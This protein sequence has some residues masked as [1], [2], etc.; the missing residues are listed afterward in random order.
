MLGS[1][2]VAAPRAEAAVDV[3]AP[4]F[5]PHVDYPTGVARRSSALGDLN[6]DSHLDV[7]TG[8]ITVSK[9]SVL[10][11]NGAGGFGAHVDYSVP[12]DPA[13]LAVADVTGDG[14][15]DVVVAQLSGVTVM[16]GDGAGHVSL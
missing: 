5:K 15:P 3:A 11:G 4:N 10:L 14:K 12:H 7:V 1:F 6:G 13:G 8:D 16:V 9:I 2:G